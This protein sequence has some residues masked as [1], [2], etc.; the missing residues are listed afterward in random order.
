MSVIELDTYRMEMADLI[1]LKVLVS[2]QKMTCRHK[3]LTSILN[4][5]SFKT[6]SQVWVFIILIMS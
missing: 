4:G 3:T 2:G 1:L 5:S 6:V